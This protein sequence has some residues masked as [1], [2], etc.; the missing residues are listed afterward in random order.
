MNSLVMGVQGNL[1]ERLGVKEDAT[2]ADIRKA[3]QVKALAY[4]PDKYPRLLGVMSVL[5]QAL[6]EARDVL[7]DVEARKWYDEV[8]Q[9]QRKQGGRGG[10][11]R[12]ESMGVR[13]DRDVDGA[14]NG[15]GEE[16][17]VPY[18]GRQLGLL[19]SSSRPVRY[20]EVR[21]SRN[22]AQDDE[23]RNRPQVSLQACLRS[24]FEIKL[25]TG[26]FGGKRQ[27]PRGRRFVYEG[28]CHRIKNNLQPS[29]GGR[30]MSGWRRAREVEGVRGVG[31]GGRGS[32]GSWG[33]VGGWRSDT[34]GAAQGAF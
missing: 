11:R 14:G 8:L 34:V 22:T 19:A 25:A 31:R 3:F 17:A 1:Y 4:H 13:R 27:L 18:S 6:S 30:N 21:L 28:T 7:T 2:Q 29:G 5:F 32:V 16:L 20:R 24:G 26:G 33:G 23:H 15:G 10:W 9:R 12:N